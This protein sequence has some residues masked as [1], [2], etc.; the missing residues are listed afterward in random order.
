MRLVREVA[1]DFK[2]DLRFNSHAVLAIQ[3]AA[4]AFLVGVFEGEPIPPGTYLKHT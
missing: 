2:S 1:Q 4:E 3:E